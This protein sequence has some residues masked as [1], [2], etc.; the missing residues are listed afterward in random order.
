MNT[1]RTETSVDLGFLEE[2]LF[3]AFFWNGGAKRPA[4]IEARARPEFSSLLAGW[5]RQGDV[6]LVAEQN[7]VA[8]G[9]AWF[10]LWTTSVN[11]YGFVDEKTPEL[12]IA[13]IPGLRGHGIGRSLIRAL[14]EAAGRGRFPGLSLSVDPAN[15]A[16]ALYESEG[17]SKVGEVGTSWTMYRSLLTS[18]GALPNQRR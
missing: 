13:V 18:P 3:E 15:P 8:A 6:L 11:S 5:G 14:L 2:M 10:R 9:A 16:R 12:G 1:I 7:G 4:L 17:F